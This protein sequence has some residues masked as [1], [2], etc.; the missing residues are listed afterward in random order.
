MRDFENNCP[1]CYSMIEFANTFLK[2]GYILDFHSGSQVANK[3]NRYQAIFSF[4]DRDSI[5]QKSVLEITIECEMTQDQHHCE[6][7]NKVH[8]S[9][10]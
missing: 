6:L 1:C 3:E 8:N 9:S 5:N 4:F 2:P 7:I 10:V